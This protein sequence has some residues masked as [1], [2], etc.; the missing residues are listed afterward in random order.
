MSSGRDHVSSCFTVLGAVS[1][2]RH[3]RVRGSWGARG[4]P[5]IR[6]W[7]MFVLF[8]E[9]KLVNW[10]SRLISSVNEGAGLSAL[11]TFNFLVVFSK[12]VLQICC[13]IHT[14]LGNVET[15][16]RDLSG[17]YSDWQ[18]I[19]IFHWILGWKEKNESTGSI[20]SIA[21]LIMRKAR[22]RVRPWF[23]YFA[24]RIC[25]IST[26]VVPFS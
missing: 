4:K 23:F 2:S 5:Q 14:F 13:L 16:T 26:E 7:Q 12:L 11:P 17:S 10:A 22:A 19:W 3:F 9:N 24:F 8:L 20:S 1:K 25:F 15:R 21:S 6:S 18:S